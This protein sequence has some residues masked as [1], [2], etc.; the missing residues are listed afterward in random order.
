MPKAQFHIHSPYK[1]VIRIKS[2]SPSV[3]ILVMVSAE[4]LE[5]RAG[6][7]RQ[8]RSLI[9]EVFIL[10]NPECRFGQ[11]DRLD[12]AGLLEEGFRRERDILYTACES[13]AES[14]K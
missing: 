7:R 3:E 13:S 10:L 2:H 11:L 12:P 4:V 9:V 1:T 14:L 5:F 6:G 8:V